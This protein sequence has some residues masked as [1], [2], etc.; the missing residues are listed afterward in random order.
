MKHTAFNPTKSTVN[1]CAKKNLDSSKLKFSTQMHTLID[2][3]NQSKLGQQQCNN[4]KKNI[5]KTSNTKNSHNKV[6][7]VATFLHGGFNAWK[8]VLF[9]WKIG[10]NS[11]LGE[12][13]VIVRAK[14]KTRQTFALRMM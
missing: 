1:N 2:R 10:N 5:L 14:K 6:A 7:V 12:D 11:S 4:N 9:W 3:R 13:F 8:R